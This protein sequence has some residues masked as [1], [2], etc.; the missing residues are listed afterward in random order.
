[1]LG[2]L[3]TFT[4]VAG[5]LGFPLVGFFVFEDLAAGVVLCLASILVMILGFGVREV[6]QKRKDQSNANHRLSS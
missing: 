3:I 1:M 6:E 2:L 4:G 5:F